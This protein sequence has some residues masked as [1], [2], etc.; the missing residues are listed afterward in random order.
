M[1]VAGHYPLLPQT[2]GYTLTPGRRMRNA[3]ALREALG[4]SGKRI[5]YLCGHLHRFSYV[6]DKDYPDLAHLSTAAFFPTR[7]SPGSQGEFTEVHVLERGFRVPRHVHRDT[8]GRE[9]VAL[10]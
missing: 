9:E 6:R 4:V 7:T 8:W 5:L 10:T 3:E 1:L 2:Y